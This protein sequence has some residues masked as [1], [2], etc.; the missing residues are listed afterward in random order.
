MDFFTDLKTA[1]PDI[2]EYVGGEAVFKSV[3]KDTK[4]MSS[5]YRDR[6]KLGKN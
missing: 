1:S 3:K 2:L 5:E 4:S 6:F